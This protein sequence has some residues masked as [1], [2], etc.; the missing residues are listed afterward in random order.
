MKTFDRKYKLLSVAMSLLF[1]VSVVGTAMADDLED[2]LN[3]IQEQ[4]AQQQQI[5]NEAAARVDSIS[6]QLRVIQ[7][8]LNNATKEY[9]DVKS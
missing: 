4:A 1:T 3:S 6:E 7:D 5:T 2:K 9:N 8:E